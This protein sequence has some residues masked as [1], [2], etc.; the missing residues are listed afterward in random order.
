MA[1]AVNHFCI[2]LHVWQG[3][4]SSE[5]FKSNRLDQLRAFRKKLMEEI[6]VKSL[7]S[8]SGTK[9]KIDRSSQQRYCIKVGFL[10]NFAKFTGKLLRQG[11][12]FNMQLYK[13]RDFGTGVFL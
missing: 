4:K 7:K 8:I 2:I 6:E 12:F 10:K 1:K 13:K 3:S 5:S 11:L 9:S